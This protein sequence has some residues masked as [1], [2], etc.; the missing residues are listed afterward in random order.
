MSNICVGELATQAEGGHPVELAS[1]KNPVSCDP[2]TAAPCA[3]PC[4]GGPVPALP[5]IWSGWE[6]PING[7]QRNWRPPRQYQNQQDLA[8]QQN[9]VPWWSQ[10]AN[11]NTSDC[12]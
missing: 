8:T 6:S 4:H 7:K 2:P 12:Q 5:N 1:G 11:V 10:I 9:Q 3:L